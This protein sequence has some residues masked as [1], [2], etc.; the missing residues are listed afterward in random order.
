MARDVASYEAGYLAALEAVHD[1]YEFGPER[2]VEQFDLWL[3]E[4]IIEARTGRPSSSAAT[5]GEPDARSVEGTDEPVELPTVNAFVFCA[6]CEHAILDCPSCGKDEW[7]LQHKSG[8]FYDEI[9]RNTPDPPDRGCKYHRWETEGH[10][11]TGD[12]NWCD[13]CGAIWRGDGTITLPKRAAPALSD[14]APLKALVEKMHEFRRIIEREEQRLRTRTGFY[15]AAQCAEA[16]RR[17]LQNC[18]ELDQLLA[19]LGTGSGK[20]PDLDEMAHQQRY[21]SDKAR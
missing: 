10:D 12:V 16:L 13:T 14:L 18:D 4:R 11:N 1:R 21:P 20:E 8:E 7:R 6:H 2:T 3:H 9:V 15:T 17:I 5:A 19:S